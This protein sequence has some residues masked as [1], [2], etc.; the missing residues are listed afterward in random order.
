[1]KIKPGYVYW[2]TGLS[3]SGKTTLG[4]LFYE[5]LKQ[6]KRSVVFFD[7]DDLREVFGNVLGYTKEER[8]ILSMQ[9][10]SLCRLLSE[11][12]FDVICATISLFHECQ[13]WN[14]ENIHKYRE[15]YVRVPMKE[16]IKRDQK[17]IYS[18]AIRGEVNNVWGIDL[19][20]EEPQKPDLI[21]DNDGF[22]PPEEVVIPLYESVEF[23]F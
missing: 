13:Q 17:Q 4:T 10:A 5:Y 23:K 11:Q 9:Y 7:G 21:I 19:E 20:I 1:M 22:K 18:R 12:G 16:L 6:H 14:S 8:K 15:I 3:G 2:I